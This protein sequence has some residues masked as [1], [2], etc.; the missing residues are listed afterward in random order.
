MKPVKFA[1]LAIFCL[2]TTHLFSQGTSCSN[3]HVLALD[4][5]SR[6]FS[7]SPTSGNAAECSS[8]FSGSGKIT[9]FRFTTDASGSCVLVHIATSAPVQALKFH[10][11]QDVEAQVHARDFKPEVV[12]ALLMEQVIGRLLKPIPFCQIQLII[13]GSGR[14]VPAH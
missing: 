2:F 14:Q 12:F 13:Y 5:I 3:P 10:G 6:T 9:I 7:V 11:T 4:S 8:G 1:I